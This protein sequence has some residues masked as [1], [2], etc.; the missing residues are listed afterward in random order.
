MKKLL[1][2]LL[3]V[4]LCASMAD[5][6]V[7]RNI[8]SKP[9][10]RATGA[11]IWIANLA[12]EEAGLGSVKFSLHPYTVG[13]P[14]AGSVRPGTPLVA[15]L[16]IKKATGHSPIITEE[17]TASQEGVT[18][19][20]TE[21]GPEGDVQMYATGNVQGNVLPSNK[22]MFDHGENIQAWTNDKF[23]ANSNINTQINYI[24]LVKYKS[25]A[26]MLRYTLN[27]R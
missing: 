15:K 10:F 25:D 21:V 11:S 9:I 17:E 27:V 22:F 2:I 19:F 24:I 13:T 18:I 12:E 1:L 26:K 7:Y 14:E 4:L 8:G 3:T 23:N 16:E 20:V 6:F 5:A